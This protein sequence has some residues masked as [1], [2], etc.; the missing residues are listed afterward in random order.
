MLD[1]SRFSSN[2]PL[3]RCLSDSHSRFSFLSAAASASVTGRRR[4]DQCSCTPRPVRVV[5][6]PRTVHM[7]ALQHG[8]G[9]RALVVATLTALALAGC[10]AKQNQGQTGSAE[11]AATPWGR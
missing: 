2:S 11:T 10:G 7:N 5:E 8:F 6:D 4:G 3:S 9:V 1:S